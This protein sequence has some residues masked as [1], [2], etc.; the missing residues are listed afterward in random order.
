MSEKS[1]T[2]AAVANGSVFASVV[3]AV[4]I[5]GRAVLNARTAD[6]FLTLAV[7][8]VAGEGVVAACRAA[9]IPAG[10][11]RSG[12]GSTVSGIGV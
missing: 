11:S 4:V 6:T 1:D 12:A 9:A 3:S 2:S 7:T 8:L 5:I 10:S